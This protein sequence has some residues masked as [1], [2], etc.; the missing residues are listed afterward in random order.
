MEDQSHIERFLATGFP[1]GY[2]PTTIPAEEALL[3]NSIL[4]YVDT[5][6][7]QQSRPRRYVLGL[8][9]DFTLLAQRLSNIDVLAK[10]ARLNLSE[11]DIFDRYDLITSRGSTTANTLT[12]SFNGSQEGIRKIEENVVD[13]F[14]NLNLTGYPSAYVYNTGQW[15][16]FKDLLTLCFRLSENARFVLCV[17]LIEYGFSI[18]RRQEFFGRKVKRPRL[19]ERVLSGYNRKDSQENGGLSLQGIAHGFFSADR[20]HLSIIA[21]KVRTGSARQK[22]FGDIDCYLGLDLELSVEVKDIDLKSDNYK[23]QLGGFINQVAAS[24][25][26]GIVF[27]SSMERE[28][29]ENLESLG[30]I[31]ITLADS[32]NIVKT[33]DYQKQNSALL[34]MLHHFAHIEQN[35]EAT[36]RLLT[37]INQTDS[38]HDALTFYQPVGNKSISDA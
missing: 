20:P 35:M 4:H 36:Q 5:H 26:L 32:I 1:K 18:F 2:S 11:K 38:N 12:L 29:L 30:I 37:F 7:R 10:K 28:V 15:H 22:R 17:K 25:V 27:C 13:L 14:H 24:G 16:K 8:A 23:N 33:W 3:V 21:D 19:F 34:G 6:I 9:L 31:T